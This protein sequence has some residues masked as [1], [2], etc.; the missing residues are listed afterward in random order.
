MAIAAAKFLGEIGA[1]INDSQRGLGQAQTA[2]GKFANGAMTTGKTLTALIT[3]PSLAAA[4]AVLNVGMSFEQS[5]VAFGKM[6][7]SGEKAKKFLNELGDFAAKTPFEFSE[8]QDA[9][10]R[11]LAYGFAAEDVLPMLRDIGDASAG[12]GVGSDG[13]NRITL[14]LGQMQGKAK[15]SAQEM[16]QLTEVGIPAWKYLADAMGLSTQ[17]VM[18]MS[19]QGLIPAKQAI[20]AILAGMRQNFGGMMEEQAKTATGQLSNLKD[21]LYLLA[22]DLSTVLLPAAKDLIGYAREAVGGMKD[23]SPETQKNIVGFIGLAAA[24]G[25]VL[26]GLSSVIGAVQTL[27]TVGGAAA[28]AMQGLGRRSR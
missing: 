21:D 25:P 8:L 16:M 7:G 11:M 17:E 26:I 13:V 3:V 23:F 2:L 5:R 27:I 4:G 14:A 19:E 24:V 6:L 22:L 1:D 18:K 28:G 15:V 9:S 10:K 12:L 20:D